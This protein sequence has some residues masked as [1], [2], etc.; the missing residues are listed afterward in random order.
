MLT[1]GRDMTGDAPAWGTSS[2]LLEVLAL[3]GSGDCGGLGVLAFDRLTRLL[4]WPALWEFAIAALHHMS[5]SGAGNEHD[6]TDGTHHFTRP[7]K[8]NMVRENGTAG[9]DGEDG[10]R[11]AEQVR[12]GVM[13]E[14]G[15]KIEAE[16]ACVVWLVTIY[17]GRRR[18][19]GA[20]DHEPEQRARVCQ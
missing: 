19:V 8:G 1:K 14:G 12:L 20:P 18:K 9:E 15:T 11:Q 16:E 3:W 10:Y 6:D 7:V 13:V 17:R 2:A 4:T 5:L